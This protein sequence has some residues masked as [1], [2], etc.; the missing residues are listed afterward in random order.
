MRKKLLTL[1]C[2]ATPFFCFSEQ[3]HF[4]FDAHR[5]KDKE[6]LFFY[7]KVHSVG[8]I[9]LTGI[10]ARV[11]KGFSGF[12]LSAALMPLNG[13]SPLVYCAKASYLFFPI[14]QGGYLSL[15]GGVLKEPETTIEI[16]PF[17]ETSLGYQWRLKNQSHVFIEG[18][19]IAPYDSS[20]NG[21]LKA[22]PGISL[23]IGF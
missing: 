11:K 3:E 23:G 13:L 22:W 20:L 15:G 10:G 8:G 5:N 18:N 2:L 4:L 21:S 1:I 16:T 12:D 19:V 9:P 7:G 6:A 17:A 14:E